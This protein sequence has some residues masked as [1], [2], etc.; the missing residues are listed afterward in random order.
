[1]S[2]PIISC[3]IRYLLCRKPQL[4]EVVVSLCPTNEFVGP[5]P[6]R[7][8]TSDVSGQ[9]VGANATRNKLLRCR[10]STCF[11]FEAEPKVIGNLTENAM[12]VDL[13]CSIFVSPSNQRYSPG[14]DSRP[15]HRHRYTPYSNQREHGRELVNKALRSWRR[16]MNLVI[17]FGYRSALCESGVNHLRR[18]FTHLTYISLPCSMGV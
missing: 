1:M 17:L 8:C 4:T 7:C 15:V 2:D 14:K 11:P 18:W 6:Q 3:T 16:L 9:V 13:G 12:N 5:P 10:P